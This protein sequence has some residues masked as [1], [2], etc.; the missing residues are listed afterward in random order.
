MASEIEDNDT[1]YQVK[2]VPCYNCKQTKGVARTI[3]ETVF[4][5]LPHCDD[6][7]VNPDEIQDKFYF[8]EIGSR[9]NW[10]QEWN[11]GMVS[12]ELYNV[13]KIRDS[14]MIERERNRPYGESQGVNL[15][16]IQSFN[17]ITD[18]F[19][20]LY[21]W[22]TAVTNEEG[23]ADV[24]TTNPS[25]IWENYFYNFNRR[26]NPRSCVVKRDNKLHPNRYVARGLR[27]KPLKRRPQKRKS[28]S[29]NPTRGRKPKKSSSKLRKRK[30][31]RR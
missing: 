11:P 28:K 10:K 18:E 30:S 7:S 29:R 19:S 13:Q 5:Q 24:D 25:D 4:R 14:K 2:W 8:L 15:S 22:I 16:E 6:C 31:R 26:C 27:R 9:S 17:P 23:Q 21:A 3:N 20:S 12:E 1:L